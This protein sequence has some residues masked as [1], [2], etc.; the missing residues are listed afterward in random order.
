MVAAGTPEIPSLARSAGVSCLRA[1]AWTMSGVG[2][3]SAPERSDFTALQREHRH[4]VAIEHPAPGHG[5]DSLA[6]GD[7]AG[8]VERVRGADR[9]QSSRSRLADA[10]RGADPPLRKARTARPTCRR[11]TARREPLPCPPDADT[12][13]NQLAPQWG[14]RLPRQQPFEHHAVATEQRTARRARRPDCLRRP[15]SPPVATNGPRSRSR[16]VRS[17]GVE[18]PPHERLALARRRDQCSKPGE[19][20]RR[21]QPQPGQLAERLLHLCGEQAGQR[22]PWKK[23]RRGAPAPREP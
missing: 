11:R 4:A 1:N 12:A 22:R 2:D 14:T 6:G 9:N 15:Q 5:R 16:T 13:M 7:D 20:V 17:G 10:L 18:R 8:Q 21:D 3:E 19:A 23:T